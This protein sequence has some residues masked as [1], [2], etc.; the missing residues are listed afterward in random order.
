MN[1]KQLRCATLCL[2]N[3][4]LLKLFSDSKATH[5]RMLVPNALACRMKPLFCKDIEKVFVTL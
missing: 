3:N 1:S 5:Q 2:K 4:L